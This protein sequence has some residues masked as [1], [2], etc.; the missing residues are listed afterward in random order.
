[1]ATKKREN[2][3]EKAI[4]EEIERRKKLAV[5]EEKR[6]LRKLGKEEEYLF[7]CIVEKILTEQFYKYVISTKAVEKPD[8]FKQDKIKKKIE[9]GIV[10]IFLVE[11]ISEN[12]T[13]QDKI[14][15]L[16]EL[17]GIKEIKKMDYNEELTELYEELWGKK[18][19]E[20]D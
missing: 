12:K 10:D 17:E 16:I 11:K 5:Y 3:K 4:N 9:M 18:E 6:E 20:N 7:F 14:I 19:K 1:M 15:R 8:Y 13:I 2:A